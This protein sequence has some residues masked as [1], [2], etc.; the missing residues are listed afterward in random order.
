VVRGGR[1]PPP[2]YTKSPINVPL[3]KTLGEINS[4]AQ[5]FGADL[6][7]G[8]AHIVILRAARVAEPIDMLSIAQSETVFSAPIGKP[9]V[10]KQ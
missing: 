1:Q 9:R 6:V 2:G 10:L 4:L 7:W 5:D 8:W 3:K